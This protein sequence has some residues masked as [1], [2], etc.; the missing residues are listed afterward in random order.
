MKKI[1]PELAVAIRHMSVDKKD[2]LL[3]RLVA[4]DRIL[5]AQLQFELIEGKS[6]T[7]ERVEDL[8]T[9][10][11]N[12]LEE[13]RNYHFT[14]GILMMNL[15]TLNARITEHVKITKDKLGEV[16]LTV[17]LLAEAFRLFLPFLQRH[18]MHSPVNF[19]EYIIR[20]LQLV[21][22]KA[23][24]LHEDYHLEFKDELQNVLDFVYNY[25]PTAR[26]AKEAQIPR[27]VD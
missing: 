26:L 15:R 11:K 2:K 10:I 6:T 9:F 24:K 12:T 21:L 7:E 18:L 3:L 4:K 23:E 16:T 14:P 13:A 5:I 27:S 25:N 1:S 17:Y 8:K 22:K 19:S 20:R